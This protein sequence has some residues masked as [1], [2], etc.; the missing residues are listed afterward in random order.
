MVIG[1]PFP[2][3]VVLISRE[4]LDVIMDD[5]PLLLT[6]AA[7][8]WRSLHRSVMAPRPPDSLTR[9]SDLRTEARVRC[10]RPADAAVVAPTAGVQAVLAPMDT[11]MRSVSVG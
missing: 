1:G 9:R 6:D 10:W 5:H 7:K 11:R 2:E 3:N 4:E 8:R